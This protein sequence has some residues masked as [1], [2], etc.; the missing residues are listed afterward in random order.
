MPL[1]NNKILLH[2]VPH[3]IDPVCFRPLEK[4]NKPLQDMKT[5]IFGDNSYD[6]VFFYNSRNVQRKRTSNII[7]AFRAFCDNLPIEKA[8]KCALVLHTEAV[9][10]AGTDLPAVIEAFCG[11]KYKVVILEDRYSPDDMNIL[12]NIADVTV[13]ISSNE[14][15]G[16]S[17]AESIMSGTPVIVNVTGGL[18]DQIG[19]TDDGG[20]VITF[21]KDFGTNHT[22]KYKKHGVWAKPVYPTARIIQGSPPTPYIFDDLCTWEDVAEAM[23]YWYT[24][25]SELREKCGNEGRRWAMN[26]GGLNVEN[27]AN[28]FIKAMD[29]TLNNFI[30]RSRFSL[31]TA[32]EYTGQFMVD[33]CLGVEIPK[34]DLN[35]INGQINELKV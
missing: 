13:N 4:D 28:Q 8:K 2:Y 11:N 19:Q 17:V 3:G 15:F 25:S 6:F 33:E 22:G 5:K 24:M 9:L 20:N 7:L 10:D 26:E 32:D 27:L 34:I 18:Q 1:K 14:G 29:F 16:L 12:Y 23:M 31:H 21:S 30:P 35:K